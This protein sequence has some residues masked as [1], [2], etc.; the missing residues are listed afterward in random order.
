MLVKL[1]EL[2]EF[3]MPEDK[4]EVLRFPAGLVAPLVEDDME[5]EPQMPL[6]VMLAQ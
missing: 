5:A 3:V 6:H 2:F 1:M 4:P